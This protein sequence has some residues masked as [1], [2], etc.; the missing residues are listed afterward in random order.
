MADAQGTEQEIDLRNYADRVLKRWWIVAICVVIAVVASFTISRT[1]NK[2]LTQ[3]TATVYLGQPISPN[4]SLVPNPLSSNPLYATALAKQR[5][6]QEVAEKAADLEPGELQ[7]HVSVAL[8]ST[9]VGV[10]GIAV[11]LAQLTVQGPFTPAQSAAAAN[12]MAEQIVA[13]SNTYTT[14]KQAAVVAARDSLQTRIDGLAADADGIRSQLDKL[15]KAS[16][17]AAERASLTAPLLGILQYDSNT[18]ALLQEQL[19]DLQAQ[20]DYIENVEGG[21][22]ITP[23]R[24]AKVAPTS[25]QFSLLIAIVLGLIVGILL[26]VLSTVF[27]PLRPVIETEATGTP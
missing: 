20:V 25:K 17:G 1:S 8:I 11:P 9:A 23:A 24:G 16:L 3:G 12:S 4:G 2:N 22:V 13:K 14:A 5:Q 19:P 7:G 21:S 6:Y 27:W 15:Q 26:A 10:K 18:E